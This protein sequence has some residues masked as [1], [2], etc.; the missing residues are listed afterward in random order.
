MTTLAHDVCDVHGASA[1][2]VKPVGKVLLYIYIY[3][4]N[5]YNIYTGFSLLVG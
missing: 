2:Y 3:N 5:M 4:M 1:F